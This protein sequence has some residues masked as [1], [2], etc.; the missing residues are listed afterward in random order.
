MK[1]TDWTNAASTATLLVFL[2]FLG[3]IEAGGTSA[4]YQ[5]AQALRARFSGK[6]FRDNVDP[7]WFADGTLFWYRLAVGPDSHEWVLVDAENG[8]RQA[9]F[10]AE[11]LAAA[12]TEAGVPNVRP[13]ALPIE[14][15]EFEVQERTPQAV[16]FQADGRRW[17]CDLQTYELQMTG[18]AE[19][20]SLPAIPPDRA[21]RA[22]RQTG[23]QV[24]LTF[25][26]RT[27]SDVHLFWLDAGGQRQNYGVLGPGQERRQNTY[28]GHV[29]LAAEAD[30]NAIAVYQAVEQPAR[31]LI[32]RE[33]TT[34]RR[35]ADRPAR[36]TRPTGSDRSTSPDQRW[37]AFIRDHNLWLRDRQNEEHEIQLST[38]GNTEDSYQPRVYWSPDSRK[39]AAIRRQPAQE[40]KVYFVE[41]S[42]RD[43]LQPR[44]HSIDYLKPGDRVAID[45]PQL[46]DV[47]TQT[48][49]PVSDELFANPYNIYG[50]RWQPDSSRV[51]FIYNQRGHQVLRVVAV[52]AETGQTAVVIDETSDTFICYSQKF[53]CDYIDDA[54][55]IIWMSERD[56]WNHLYL[57]DAQ[58][59]TVKNQI[60]QGQW[61]VRSVDYV[62]KDNRQIWFQLSGYYPEQDPYYVHYARVN[63]DGMEL[64]L[65]TESDGTHSVRFS[66]DRR[67]AVAQWSR[68][69]HPP[70]HELRRCED[71]TR[72]CVLEQADAS[73][74][75]EAGWQTPEPFVAKARDG[76]T[77][78]YGVIVRPTTFDPNISYPIIEH[79]YAGP[80][81][82][83]VP[84]GFQPYLRMMQMAELGFILVQIDGMGT[85]NRSKAFHDVCWQ[86]LA[87]AGLPD[88]VL[89]I[90][91]A[92]DKYPY[93]DTQR[94][95]I[96]G[97]SAGGQNAAAAVMTHG[98]FYK[99]AVADCGCHDNR[100]DK[101][102]WNEQWMGWPVGP[103]YEANSNVTLAPGLKGKL[104]LIVGEMDTNV[105]PASTMQV[106]DALIRADK[107][108]DMLI[109]PGAGHGAAEGR[110]ASRRRADFFVRHLLGSE[111][112]RQ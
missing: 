106:V 110:Y 104:L 38:D 32:G 56:G 65:L 31:V 9:A 7:Q 19:E 28:A 82:S 73:A 45:K 91:A 8:L 67:F 75:F 78:I 103:H 80:Q 61:V 47:E 10:D 49:I 20:E 40:R 30:G 15:L 107:D 53:F 27:D 76:K 70:V 46:F 87:D 101:I 84:K 95:G 68:V 71:G 81:G 6:V 100:M 94:V 52:D 35:G 59:G 112:R 62:D 14:Q 18:Q 43:Q 41:S 34:R 58:T 86:N 97:G 4:D 44:L 16:Q 79:I 93:M 98:D 11:R 66:P 92:S 21:P 60:T 1:A 55:E 63:F 23:R 48:H 102:W 50:L 2:F 3:L 26:N 105:D 64:T 12:L 96:Y 111:P 33:N 72:L 25:V 109:V 108:F 42:P 83:F 85:S 74:L 90:K 99:V 13:E 37:Q 77:D 88:R 36:R 54:D 5:R 51:T 24:I 57:Y 69:N 29:W 17:R 39:L 89:W 22:S